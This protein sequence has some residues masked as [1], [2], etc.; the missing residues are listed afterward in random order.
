MIIHAPGTIDAANAGELRDQFVN[1]S[2]IVPT[3][4]DLIG[5]TP[6]RPTTGSNSSR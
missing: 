3:L 5:V 2:D 6:P 1:V 4:Y